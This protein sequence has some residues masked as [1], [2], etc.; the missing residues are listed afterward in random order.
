MVDRGMAQGVENG[1]SDRVSATEN[2]EAIG[3]DL[4]FVE[5]GERAVVAIEIGGAD[6]ARSSGP[7]CGS[8]TMDNDVAGGP[9]EQE[10]GESRP[11]DGRRIL[12]SVGDVRRVPRSEIGW[13]TRLDHNLAWLAK[14]LPHRSWSRTG[15]KITKN[16]GKDKAFTPG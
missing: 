12:P 10:G 6:D 13:G 4:R 2:G 3:G 1:L 9:K 14:T 5:R 15:M 7:R 8:R 11:N 16:V